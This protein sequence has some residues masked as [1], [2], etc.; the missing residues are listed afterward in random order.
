[1]KPFL[2]TARTA[3]QCIRYRALAASSS[4]AAADASD[5]F[6]DEPCG[7]TVRCQG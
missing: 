6:G 4:Q 7:V 3:T 1:M 2:V 5:L